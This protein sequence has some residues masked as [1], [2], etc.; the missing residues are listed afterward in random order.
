MFQKYKNFIEFCC[1]M[2]KKKD[3][4]DAFN[5]AF[6]AN[7]NLSIENI[8]IIAANSPAPR[9]YC[10]FEQARRIVSLLD[11]GKELPIENENKIR[12]YKELH[13]RFVEARNKTGIKSFSLLEEIITQPAPSFYLDFETFRALVYKAMNEKR[14][15]KE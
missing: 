1:I 10:T 12:M 8:M 6:A 4:L 5:A 3:C 15:G 7:R 13:R 11:R 2:M 9:F 14:R